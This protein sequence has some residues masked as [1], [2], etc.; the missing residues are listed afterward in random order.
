MSVID[1]DGVELRCVAQGAAQKRKALG[2]NA[3]RLL[4]S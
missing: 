3:A 4:A 2:E 1:T